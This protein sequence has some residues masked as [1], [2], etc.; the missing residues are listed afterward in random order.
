MAALPRHP[1]AGGGR[2]RRRFARGPD[3]HQPGMVLLTGAT[4]FVG[5]Q[6]LG[7]LLETTE[8]SVFALVRAPDAAAARTRI[9]G[10]LGALYG[11]RPPAADRVVAVPGDVTRPGLG[12]SA[13]DHARIVGEAR[14]V[15]HG[16]AAVAFDRSEA[17]ATTSNVD[18]TR[19]VMRL[20]EEMA[21]AGAGL[22]RV[23]HVSTAYVAGDHPGVFGEGDLDVGQTT[24]N[25]YERSK[26]D[27]ERILR[28]DFAHLP[29]I[30]VRPSIVVGEQ[31]SG[32]TSAFNVLYWPLRAFASGLVEAVPANPEAQVDVVPVDYVAAGVVA[33]LEVP[34]GA[35]SPVY[36]LVAGAGANS[37]A[38]L[39]RMAGEAFA[40][41]AV[42]LVEGGRF[43][44]EV[45][46]RIAD[47]AGAPQRMA[48]E[49]S[50]IYFPYFDVRTR[51]DDRRAR[52]LLA[53]LG[54]VAPVLPDYFERIV[55]YALHASWGKRP[56][57]R[58]QARARAVSAPAARVRA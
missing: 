33:A 2:A 48:L 37:V 8:R 46:P 4:G 6:I 23:V 27:A 26:L 40:R 45:A 5:G 18:G 13:A 52:E 39:A 3:G 28:A 47:E 32:W 42:E 53:P 41:P 21:A 57:T 43:E 49:Q 20:A 14:A 19:H 50:R 36:H 34:P 7:R 30:V 54:I 1:G 35:G 24:R 31:T 38:E 15:V 56:E 58:A 44:R 12:L 51:F 22:Q 25:S 10:V 17:D 55:D 9:D 16:A 29:V 11:E